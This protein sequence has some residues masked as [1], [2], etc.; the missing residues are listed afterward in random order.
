MRKPLAQHDGNQ[1][2]RDLN[3]DLARL[4]GCAHDNDPILELGRKILILEKEQRVM[5]RAGVLGNNPR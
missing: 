3:L 4:I 1:R 5:M 2:S